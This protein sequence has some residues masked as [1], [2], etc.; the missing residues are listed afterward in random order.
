MKLWWPHNEALTASSVI[1]RD[2]GIDKYLDIFEQIL[3]YCKIHF[4]D[5]AY[6]E[7][8]GYLRRD[9]KPTEPACKGSTF[10][11]PFHVLRCLIMIDQMLEQLLSA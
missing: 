4:A 5:E 7:W 2:T 9:G 8:C 6:G 10:K 11:G 1:Y 3:E